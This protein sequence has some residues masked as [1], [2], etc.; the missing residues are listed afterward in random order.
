MRLKRLCHPLA[1]VLVV[2]SSLSFA[3]R[4]AGQRQA[5]PLTFRK[6]SDNLYEILGGRGANGGAFIGGD[7]VLLIDSKMDEASVNQVLVEIKKL[8]DKPVKYMVN[9]HAD[10]DHVNGNRYL[11]P[12]TTFVAHENC[13]K[14][15]F[16]TTRD[17][18]PSQWSD[19]KLSAFV[20]S[21]TYRTKMDIYLGDR[22]VE[23]WYFGVGHT[24]GDTV[25]YFPEEK[26]A[27]VGDQVFLG[28]TPLIHA[29]KGGNSFENVKTLTKMLETLDAE[30][31]CTGHSN[32]TDREG[33]KGSIA[34]MRQRQEKVKALIEKG[35]SLDEIRA[36]FGP[37]E[38]QLI[39]IIHNEISAAKK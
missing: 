39:A 33:V 22:R 27:F 2:L 35:K 24:T 36:E 38:A 28:R 9:T 23:L 29:Y 18:A 7:G 10:G 16:H 6:T 34:S 4:A 13:R 17:G 19:P 3:Q 20:P 30:H 31:F 1:V 14:E 26:T 11:P 32:V 12:G 21:I 37:D 8:T 5:A 15:F 25:V